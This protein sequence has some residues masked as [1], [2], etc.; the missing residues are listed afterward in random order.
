MDIKAMVQEIYANSPAPHPAAGIWGIGNEYDLATQFTVADVV[1]AVKYLIQAEDALNIPPTQR[2]PITS[3]VSFAKPD[4]N[5]PAITA[6]QRLKTE[7][8]NQGMDDVW[9]QRFIASMN[10]FNDGSFLKDYIDNQFPPYFP[11]LPFFFAEMGVQIQA[12][13]PVTNEQQQADYVLSQIQ[14]SKPRSNFLGVC[15]FQFLNQSA[16]KQGPEA[17]FGM[18]KYSGTIIATGTILPAD[19]MPGGGQSYNVDALIQK[20]LYASVQQGFKSWNGTSK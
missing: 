1:T 17:T 19:Y 8:H 13:T 5:P 9:D 2:L 20:P 14:N 10:P 16:V 11:S 15:V 3:P 18:T 12:G 6:I 4:N 7:F